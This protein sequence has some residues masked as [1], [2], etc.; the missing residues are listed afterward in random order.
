[1]ATTSIWAVKGWLGQVV[2]YVE[3]PDKTA[4]PVFYQKADMTESQTQGLSDVIDY[5]VQ[6]RKTKLADERAEVRRHF[7]TAINCQADT[8]RDEMMATKKHFGK[9][10]GVVAYHGYQSFAPGEA[11][12]DMAHEIGVKLA[13]K[14]WGDRYQVIVT[15]HLD[16][17][18]HLHNHFVLNNVA[19]DNGKKYYRSEHDYWLM[20]HESDALCREYGL[21]V[22]EEPKRGQSKHYGER[23]AER[24]GK[25]T[26]RGLV[27]ADLDRAIR[28]S[29]TERQ[30]WDNLY[31]KGC[32]TE[33]ELL[34]ALISK[35]PVKIVGVDTMP[36]SVPDEFGSFYD[37]ANDQ[38]LVHKGMEFHNT[39][40]AV[41]HEL[42]FAEL[43]TGPDTQADP[44]FSAY[45]ASYLLCK[46]Y[47]V[48]AQGFI[49][50]DAPDVFYGMDAQAIKGELSQIRDVAESI[51]G[52]MARQLEAA[53][54]AAKP[55]DAR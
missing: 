30:L 35:A 15:T 14:L 23:Q 54:K 45:C 4:N 42:A 50:G 27:K 41:A 49:F 34:G 16:K 25:P 10:E 28:E 36:T 40:R 51:S 19:M 5:A 2:I 17:S 20:Q 46:K 13:R 47:G 39:F 3:N 44:S 1:M 9:T 53:Q 12:P 43:T 26:Y 31:K 22:I 55:P 11:T 48:D 37:Q 24:T 7:I 52:R 8:A 32:H 6:S 29:V 21:S 18:N 38:I 33:R